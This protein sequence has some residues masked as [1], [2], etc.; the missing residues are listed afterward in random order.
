L[1]VLRLRHR[2][3]SEVRVRHA[4]PEKSLLRAICT[5]I[6]LKRLWQ[7]T[8]PHST[9]QSAGVRYLHPRASVRS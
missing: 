1:P 3:G 8:R 7:E 2:P 9:R 5:G 4:Q 6:A